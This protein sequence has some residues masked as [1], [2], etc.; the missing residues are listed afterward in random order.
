MFRRV[1]VM[2]KPQTAPSLQF[3]AWT[4]ESEMVTEPLLSV[5]SMTGTNELVITTSFAL[6]TRAPHERASTALM[7]TAL[8]M[9][10]GSEY[11]V[12]LV[13]T[14]TPVLSAPGQSVRGAIP[15]GTEM[16]PE[17]ADV[18]PSFAVPP[19]FAGERFTTR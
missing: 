6:M 12:R 14:G 9:V 1:A 13:P 11:S 2:L 18:L 3:P 4:V 5:A 16:D 8:E 7:V 17:V 15:E 19:S 10:H